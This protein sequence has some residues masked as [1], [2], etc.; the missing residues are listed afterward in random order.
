MQQAAINSLAERYIPPNLLRIALKGGVFSGRQ[1]DAAKILCLWRCA[2]VGGR[3]DWG[4]HKLRQMES[5]KAF[6]AKGYFYNKYGRG[7][8]NGVP[9]GGTS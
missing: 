6:V 2:V 9:L 7:K 4:F 3:A 8:G 5:T 1:G